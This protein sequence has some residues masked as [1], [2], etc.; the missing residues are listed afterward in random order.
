MAYSKQKQRE[1]VK[2]HYQNNKN[3]YKSR[4]KKN[5][6][7][8]I[9]RN[10]K[11]VNDFKE[12]KQ[13]CDCSGKFV[14]IQ[15]DFDHLGENKDKNIAQMVNMAYSIE[16]IKQEIEKCEVV[17]ASCHRLRTHNRL[18]PLLVEQVDT[19]VSKTFA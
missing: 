4:A 12:A 2:L 14:A 6:K 15:L 19:E 1:Y 7:I 8:H 16:R 5:R 13:C 17:C 10:K 11:F 18:H 3:L 9:E